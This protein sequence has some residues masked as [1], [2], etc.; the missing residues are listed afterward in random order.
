[1]GPLARDNIIVL[2]SGN[3]EQKAGPNAYC[4]DAWQCSLTELLPNYR[5]TSL[6][7]AALEEQVN[8]NQLVGETV[9]AVIFPGGNAMQYFY[10]CRDSVE[11][12]RG[13]TVLQNWCVNHGVALICSCAVAIFVGE[14]YFHPVFPQVSFT[15]PFN[16]IFFKKLGQV[17]MY[18]D[19]KEGLKK[20]YDLEEKVVKLRD[21]ATEN[22]IKAL[23]IA[24]PGMV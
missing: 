1:M 14:G 11:S 17:G 7:I 4:V 2:N 6:C 22:R 9:A 10:L 16:H 18:V 19:V 21:A 8:G 13:Y 24:G 23:F 12:K 15:L 20:V 5:I 3:P